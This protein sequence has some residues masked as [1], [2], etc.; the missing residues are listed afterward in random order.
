MAIGLNQVQSDEGPRFFRSVTIAPRRYLDPKTGEKK[1]SGKL[2]GTGPIWSSPTGA[3][4]KIYV[5]SEDGV[6]S[7][8]GTGDEFQVLG[9]CTFEGEGPCKGSV[10]AAQ[11]MVFFRT[12]KNLYAFGSR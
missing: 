4:G 6:A 11:G 2:P 1:W 12:A 10:A 8:V 5:V 9:T 7:V 3:D